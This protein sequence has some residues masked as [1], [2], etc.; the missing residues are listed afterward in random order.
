M[1]VHDVRLEERLRGL[2][3]ELRGA[4][5]GALRAALAAQRVASPDAIRPLHLT[6]HLG[7]DK[8]LASRVVRSLGAE[9]DIA[10]LHGIPTPQGLGLIARALENAGADGAPLDRFAA[11]TEAYAAL[12]SEFSGGRTDLEATLAGWLPDQRRRAERDARRSVFRG[13]TTLVG[14][15][16]GAVYNALLLVPSDEDGRVDSLIVAV[17]QDLRRLR[18]G[19]S[20]HV[21]RL[22]TAAEDQRRSTLDGAPLTGDPNNLIIGELCSQPLPGLTLE[23]TGDR[24]LI[25]IAADSLDVNESTTLGIGWRTRGHFAARGG[26]APMDR[27]TV[28]SERPCEALVLDVLVHSSLGRVSDAVAATSSFAPHPDR[29]GCGGPPPPGSEERT[30]AP[31]VERLDGHPSGLRSAAV[32]AVPAIIENACREAGFGAD[33]FTSRIRMTRAFPIPTEHLT[34]WWRLEGP[35]EG[36]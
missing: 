32:R 33:E 28:S 13:M 14:T 7:L 22:E 25:E 26:A 30:G 9:D 3:A 20:V 29:S 36:A 21:A 17:R 35:A 6:S 27:L 23:E 5:E 8:S 1:T 31:A 11:A 15:R 12:L 18:A 16:A 24:L 19:A 4:L 34:L 10:A 2:A